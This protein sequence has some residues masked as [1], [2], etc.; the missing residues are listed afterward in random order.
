[1]MGITERKREQGDGKDFMT[2]LVFHPI[3]CMKQVIQM[4]E[5]LLKGRW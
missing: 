1:M 5:V 4:K 3:M 2:I